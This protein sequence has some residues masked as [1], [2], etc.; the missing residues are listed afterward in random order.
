MKEKNKSKELMRLKNKHNERNKKAKIWFSEKAN[1]TD[2]WVTEER[3][4]K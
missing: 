3:G 1:N 4:C 2:T